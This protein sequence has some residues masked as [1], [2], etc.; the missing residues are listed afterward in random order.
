MFFDDDT[1]AK[2]V[3]AKQESFLRKAANIA[4]RSP[5][6]HRHGCLIVN[7]A[8]DII[9]EGYN[10]MYVH[11][12]HK[13]SIHAEVS[14]LSKLKRNR[15]L[16]DCSMYVVRIGT[17]NM[18]NPLKYSRPCP[19]CTKAIIKSG[20]KKVYYSTSDEFYCKIENM[21]FNS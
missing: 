11:M 17:D 15:D 7:K 13:F 14:C 5:M 6:T 16:S 8:G 19:D 21:R 18:Q 10:H 3:H 20:I 1:P 2:A 9:S 12:Y 4:I